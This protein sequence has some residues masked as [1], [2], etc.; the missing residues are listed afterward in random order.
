MPG[1]A[2][3][4]CNPLD[5]FLHSWDFRPEPPLSALFSFFELAP[6]EV[7]M[8]STMVI[9][10]ELLIASGVSLRPSGEQDQNTGPCRGRW[11]CEFW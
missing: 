5:H 11:L 6:K 9:G 4:F 1:Q 8:P 10:M 7:E 2:C 3:N